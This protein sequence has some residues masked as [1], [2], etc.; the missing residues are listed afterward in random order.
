VPFV[1]LELRLPLALSA[2]HPLQV[3][4]RCTGLP[5]DPA[6]LELREM[7]LEEADLMLVCRTGD[8]GGTPLDREMVEDGTF[9]D[10]CL[11]LRDEFGAPHVLVSK[12]AFVLRTRMECVLTEFHLAVLSIVTLA[13]CFEPVSAVFLNE[14]ER[15][16][17]LETVPDPWM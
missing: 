17:Y 7:A 14:G 16:T 2:D 8:I 9:V 1:G 13:P 12:S 10:S 3:G 11:G 5:I 4:V 6:V 15:L